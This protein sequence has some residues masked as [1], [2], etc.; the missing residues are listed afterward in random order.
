MHGK[1]ELV[2]RAE[3]LY[4]KLTQEQQ[5][6]VKRDFE[7]MYGKNQKDRTLDQWRKLVDKYGIDTVSKT[8]KMS[9]KEI[10]AKTNSGRFKIV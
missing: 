1:N 8:E 9:H 7:E 6:G 3:K 4:N 2:E 5:E 10:K